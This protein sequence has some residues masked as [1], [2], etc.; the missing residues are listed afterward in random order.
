MKKQSPLQPFRSRLREGLW[1]ITFL[2]LLAATL[3][4]LLIWSQVA[5]HEISVAEQAVLILAVT[6]VC[7]LLR[8]QPLTDVLGRANRESIRD[9]VVGLLLGVALMLVPAAVLGLFGSVTWAINTASLMP[10]LSVVSVMAAVAV[11]EELL[12]RGF[13]FQRL[14]GAFGPWA[15]QLAIAGLFLLTHLNNPGMEG[16]AKLLAS[17]NIFLA[18]ILFGLA[19]LRTGGLAMPIGIHFAANAMQGAMLGMAV[20]G[21]A[22]AGLL[23]PSFHSS[24]WLTGGSFGLEASLPG[25]TAVVLAV[26][27]LAHP[28]LWARTGKVPT[29][30]EASDA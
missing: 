10:T 2:G 9:L 22:Q 27:L 11:A 4:P 20:S 8:K 3:A 7:Q 24:G 26:A 23:I 13:L 6:W 18:S 17:A 25:L 5:G 19:Y 16:S 28:R 21:N 12:F 14:I 15:A 29:V 30:K 1:A